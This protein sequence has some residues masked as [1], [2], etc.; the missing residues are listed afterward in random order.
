MDLHTD[1][2]KFENNSKP[3]DCMFVFLAF[4]TFY[5][6]KSLKYVKVKISYRLSNCNIFLIRRRV[7]RRQYPNTSV[8]DIHRQ[9]ELFTWKRPFYKGLIAIIIIP[10]IIIFLIRH[11][12]YY[13]YWIINLF[14]CRVVYCINLLDIIRYLG[15]QPMPY[16]SKHSLMYETFVLVVLSLK[17]SSLTA[18]TSP[19]FFELTL[20]L[21]NV[22]A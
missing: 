9:F 21:L 17:T 6:L 12:H 11:H 3:F 8:R 15:Y 20:L 19:T 22:S 18:T 7:T 2:N 1:E 4:Y 14:I 10:I 13:H 16:V 5:W